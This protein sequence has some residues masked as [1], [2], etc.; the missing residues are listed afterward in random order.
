MRAC[1]AVAFLLVLGL[2]IRVVGLEAI[3]P[4]LWSDEANH[5][6]DVREMRATGHVPVFFPSNCG[7]EPLYKYLVA[8]ATR[9]SGERPLAVRLPA[10]V[11]G[12]LM[13]PF[14][15]VWVR[16]HRGASAASW[17]LV[18]LT[19]G[20]WHLQFSRIGFR[21]IMGPTVVMGALLTL[22]GVRTRRSVGAAALGGVMAGLTWYTYPAHRL[23]PVIGALWLILV[24][25]REKRR[26]GPGLAAY[27]VGFGL[28]LIPLFNAWRDAPEL[29]TAR[30][31]MAALWSETPDV[32][33][34]VARNTWRHLGMFTVAGDRNWRHNLSGAP[35]LDPF[36]GFFFILGC[37]RAVGRRDHVDK[38]LLAWLVLM[39][40]PGILSVERQA[41]H[42]L[43]TIGVLPVPYILAADGLLVAASAP[44]GT[45][46]RRLGAILVVALV[47]LLNMHRYF[48]A[49]PAHLARLSPADE[50]LYGFNRQEYALARWLNGQGDRGVWLSPQLFLH[51]TV[52]YLAKGQGHR[53]LVCPDSLRAGDR[54]VLQLAPRNLWW[55]RDDFR[56]NFF[57]YWWMSGRATEEDTWRAIAEGY[58]SCTDG[59]ASA[60]DRDILDSVERQWEL[61]PDQGIAGLHVFRVGARRTATPFVQSDLAV[62]RRVP[63]G[64]VEVRIHPA[65]P[66]A[67][68]GLWAKEESDDRVRLLDRMKPEA[69]GSVLRGCL[70]WPSC[71][72]VRPFADPTASVPVNGSLAYAGRADPEPY[73]RRTLVA[74]LGH[75]WA[76]A[77]TGVRAD[78][79]RG[80]PST[81]GG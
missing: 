21:A 72:S 57:L 31:S 19:F 39:L 28:C 38:V 12:W 44:C 34:G 9:V 45:R 40:M 77:R 52:A 46:V 62:W 26:I 55:L 3:P 47:L 60:D 11:V 8:L 42:S 17:T 35:Q 27:M 59:L 66:S 22:E 78:P 65:D 74:R 48:V 69:D 2:L 25:R 58:P 80:T 64:C 14:A 51:P 75:A 76:R 43:R 16:R 68:L 79:R 49:W 15:Y 71:V 20:V 7:Q 53:L 29:L 32:L 18:F 81:R 50:S 24:L 1:V 63:A 4:A 56:K 70:V 5:G 23:L 36:T 37:A 33:A 54:M 41:P 67:D 6:L 10:A 13:L 30:S 73:L 61:E